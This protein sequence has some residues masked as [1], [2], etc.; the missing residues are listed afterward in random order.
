MN[1]YN[2]NLEK[3]KGSYSFQFNPRDCFR[4]N[5]AAIAQIIE[6]RQNFTQTSKVQNVPEPSFKYRIG[7]INNEQSL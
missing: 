2:S 1:Y 4:I 6:S 5:L 3:K 7:D